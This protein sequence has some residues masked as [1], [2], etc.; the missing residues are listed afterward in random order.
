MAAGRVPP[1]D[2]DA[3]A[4]LLGAMLLTR[5]ALSEASGVVRAD[6]FYDPANRQIYE[7][8]MRV[9]GRGDPVEVITVAA[10]LGG[11]NW[12]PVL[13]RRLAACGSSAHAAAYARLVAE[14]G[15]ERRMAG[16]ARQLE[17]APDRAARLALA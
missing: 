11:E 9:W 2:L 1:C 17:V 14:R 10:E 15:Q 13:G 12:K 16:L 8:I 7:A 4:A 5:P 3:E 6:D